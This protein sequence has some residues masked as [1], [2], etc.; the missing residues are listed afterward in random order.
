MRPGASSPDSEAEY[1]HAIRSCCQTFFE[2]ALACRWSP[3]TLLDLTGY[4]V[5]PPYARKPRLSLKR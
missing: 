2:A 1:T 4:T 5:L 3:Y